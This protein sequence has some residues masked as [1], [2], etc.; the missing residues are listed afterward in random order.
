MM[1]VSVR[2]RDLTELFMG[3]LQERGFICNRLRVRWNELAGTLCCVYRCAT[4]VTYAGQFESTRSE[5]SGQLILSGHM[6]SEA[7]CG[8]VGLEL[9][10]EA[11]LT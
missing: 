5:L 2:M 8:G 4:L 10:D 9:R 3:S 7:L 1:I 11:N 6:R